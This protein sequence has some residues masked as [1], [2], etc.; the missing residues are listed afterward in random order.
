MSEMITIFFCL[1]QFFSSFVSIACEFL[2][3]TLIQED[4][5]H[6]DTVTQT[7]LFFHPVQR[8]NGEFCVHYKRLSTEVNIME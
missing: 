3:M 2:T 4:H 7:M 6:Y 1:M 5:I 8:N